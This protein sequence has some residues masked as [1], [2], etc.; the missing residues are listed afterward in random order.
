MISNAHPDSLTKIINDIVGKKAL[1]VSDIRKLKSGQSIK[2]ILFDRN[3]GDYLHGN[4][5]DKKIS[6]RKYLNEHHLATYTHKKGLTGKI[7][8]AMNYREDPWTWEI[9]CVEWEDV[10]WCP[11]SSAEGLTEEKQ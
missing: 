5:K 10:Y 7:I 1:K 2:V 4:E 3:I 8:D 6:T 11:I 9:N